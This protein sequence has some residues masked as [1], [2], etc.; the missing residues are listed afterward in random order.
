MQTWPALQK[1]MTKREKYA[2]Y[3]FGAPLNT[4]TVP[5]GIYML[6]VNNRDT[7]TRCEMCSMA[8]FWFLYC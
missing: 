8:L 1:I 7:R 4:N 2:E 6:K 3:N 5:A